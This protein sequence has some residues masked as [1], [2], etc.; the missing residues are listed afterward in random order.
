LAL[1]GAFWLQRTGFIADLCN[2]KSGID[3]I[4]ESQWLEKRE[5]LPV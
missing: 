2:D 5:L 3:Q 1:F 4:L